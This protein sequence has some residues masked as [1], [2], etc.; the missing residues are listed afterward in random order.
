MSQ[1][2]ELV[3]EDKRKDRPALLSGGTG[4]FISLTTCGGI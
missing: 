1:L 3:A 4:T 2:L